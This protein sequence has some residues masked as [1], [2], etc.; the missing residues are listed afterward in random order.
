MLSDPPHFPFVFHADG[1]PVDSSARFAFGRGG[2]LSQEQ[3][4]DAYIEQVEYVN[5]QLRSVIETILNKSVAPPIILLQADHGLGLSISFNSA[6]N[7]CLKERFSAFGAY[8]L[9]GANPNVIP[10]DITPVNLFRII[11][12]EYFDADLELVENRQYFTKGQNMFTDM[13][14]VTEQVR[15][16]CAVTPIKK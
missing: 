8:Y 4:R 10:Q 14:D 3:Y 6:E 2:E 5:T 11:F 12:N 13:Q 15:N 1:S 16:T 7:A 9:P